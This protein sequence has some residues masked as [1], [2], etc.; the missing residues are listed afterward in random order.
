MSILGI[1]ES[2][3]RMDSFH[4]VGGTTGRFAARHA[5]LP[6]FFACFS[7]NWLVKS[8]IYLTV[9]DSRVLRV[10]TWTVNYMM[11]FSPPPRRLL[12]W[13]GGKGYHIIIYMPK[14]SKILNW[15][16]ACPYW[17]LWNLW[18]GWTHSMIWG[19]PQEGLRHGM[20]FSMFFFAC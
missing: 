20:H 16:V 2:M 5:H 11:L 17:G 7:F 9:Q 12:Q 10:L 1:V 14:V 3:G 6:C 8:I 13:V 15:G 18:R 19:A 4:D